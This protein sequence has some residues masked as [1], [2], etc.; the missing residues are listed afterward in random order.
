MEVNPAL[1]SHLAKLARLSPSP[2]EAQ[3]LQGDLKNILAMVQKLDELDLQTVQPLRYVTGQVNDLR[4]DTVGQHIDRDA[5]LENAP[6]A[7][8]A[9]GFFRVPK[10]IDGAKK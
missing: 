2:A 9:G 7:D 10:V 8:R 1:L 3:K 5:A 6:D 4:P